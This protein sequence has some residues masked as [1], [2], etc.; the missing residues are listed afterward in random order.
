MRT[1]LHPALSSPAGLHGLSHVQQNYTDT[2]GGLKLDIPGKART[3]QW[4]RCFTGDG[5]SWGGGGVTMSIYIFFIYI[6]IDLCFCLTRSV[7]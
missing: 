3:R 5:L 7:I 2:T 4:E 6:S 1:W